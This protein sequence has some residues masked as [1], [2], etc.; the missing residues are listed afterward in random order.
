MRVFAYCG[1]TFRESTKKIAG[2]SPLTC[3]PITADNFNPIWL[4]F[5]DLIIFDLHGKKGSDYWFELQPVQGVPFMPPLE[6]K[7]LT[8]E[9]I[10]QSD[11]TG[12]VVMGLNCYLGDID[13][14]MLD[15]LLYAGAAYVI[16]GEGANWAIGSDIGATQLAYLF[17]RSLEKGLPVLQSL[18]RAKR[19]ISKWLNW[20]KL[21]GQN[22]RVKAI[23]DSLEFKAIV[24]T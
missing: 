14:P 12:K 7:A 13:N 8:A 17:R 23:E 10:R 3:P 21:S 19:G 18:D 22:E 1:E 11:L 16:S 24:G 5:A 4:N 20:Y 6:I 9:K 2:V 15:A